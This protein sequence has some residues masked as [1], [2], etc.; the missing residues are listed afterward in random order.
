[1]SDPSDREMYVS[2]VTGNLMKE[3]LSDVNRFVVSVTVARPK[4]MSL[5]SIKK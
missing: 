4:Q 2:S 5:F 3:K 1:M